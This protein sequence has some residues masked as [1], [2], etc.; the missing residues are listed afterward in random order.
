MLHFS[1]FSIETYDESHDLQTTAM[2]DLK[3]LGWSQLVESGNKQHKSSLLTGVEKN[4]VDN[5]Q[6]HI[7]H[8]M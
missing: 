6:D 2:L 7:T 8:K 4:E 5:L 3:V 1:N